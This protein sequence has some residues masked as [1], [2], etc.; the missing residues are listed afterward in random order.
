MLNIKPSG[1]LCGDSRGQCGNGMGKRLLQKQ[2]I[3]V[4]LCSLRML[5]GNEGGLRKT[6]VKS[7]LIA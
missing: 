3:S 2:K 1:G 7:T 4:K 5:K 6:V